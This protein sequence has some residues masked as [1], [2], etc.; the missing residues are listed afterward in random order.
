MKVPKA[1]S[2]ID[3][4]RIDRF[5]HDNQPFLEREIFPSKFERI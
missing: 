1:P 4:R 5:L 2:A 3:T